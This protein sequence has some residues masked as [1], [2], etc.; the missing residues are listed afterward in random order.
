MSSP[1]MT[2]I[3]GFSEAAVS[4]AARTEAN[5]TVL[6]AS[7]NMNKPL[8]VMASILAGFYIIKECFLIFIVYFTGDEIKEVCIHNV[9]K[10]KVEV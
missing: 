10:R 7:E 9:C 5:V 4:V 1:Q 8:K 3:L 2:R 6:S